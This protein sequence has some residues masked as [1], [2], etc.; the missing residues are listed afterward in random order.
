MNI[1]YY[2]ELFIS[3]YLMESIALFVDNLNYELS[4]FWG[5]DYVPEYTVFFV[6]LAELAI[7]G[8]ILYLFGYI[9]YF[10]MSTIF[11]KVFKL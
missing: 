9:V 2:I 11:R 8:F 10:A 3:E 4:L 7:A 6:M 1:M 5:F